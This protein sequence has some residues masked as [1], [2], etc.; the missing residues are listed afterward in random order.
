MPDEVAVM[1]R[2]PN[3]ALPT[4]SATTPR[5]QTVPLCHSKHA[6]VRDELWA[7]SVFNSPQLLALGFRLLAE[8]GRNGSAPS[9]PRRALPNVWNRSRGTTARA[10]RFRRH[11]LLFRR[12]GCP[13]T[14][15]AHRPNRCPLFMLTGEY[16]YSCT[17]ELSE[18]TAAKIPASGSRARPL[19]GPR[20][21]SSHWTISWREMDSNLRFRN[22]SVPISGQP[23]R[24]PSR[25][26]ASR[27][28]TGSS[29]PFPST[30]ES[31]NFR[32]LIAGSWRREQLDAPH[33]V[34]NTCVLRADVH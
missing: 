1:P 7:V 20:G 4:T 15:W 8:L 3:S 23:V 31:T 29:N 12:V 9:A 27:P 30:G 22:R 13:P 14:R 17:L 26:T 5:A 6:Q 2:P 33:G 24:L 21:P 28:G 32:F 18:A 34:R 19:A 10:A 16:D 25:L 11:C